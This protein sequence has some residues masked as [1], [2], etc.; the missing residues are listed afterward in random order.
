[1]SANNPTGK[2]TANISARSIALPVEHGAWGFLFEPLAVG[3]ILAPGLGA[4]FIALAVVGA[5]LL[6]QPLKFL[7]GDLLQKRRLS[8]THI[9]RRFVLI[10][11]C[12]AM[13]GLFGQL[14]LAPIES[15]VPFA[16]VTPIA[17]YMLAQDVARQSRQ[18]LP[19][20]LAAFVLASSV[21]VLTIADGFTYPFALALWAIMLARLLPSVL[22][23][24]SRLRLEKGREFSRIGPIAA[25][26]VALAVV[27]GLYY[28]GLSSILTI[29]MV[30][31]LTGR[32]WFGLSRYRQVLKAKAIGIWEVIYGILYALSVVVGY[33][34]NI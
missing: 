16:L 12:I 7:L 24:R 34:L 25:H 10:F 32:A 29:L 8:R 3:L 17:V 18:L 14:W 19:E 21:T 30:A 9:A 20:L 6:R 1:M 13:T 28:L 5:F 22:Y 11:G 27:L 31:F 2:P 4:P 15:L 33:Y 26:A 23:V